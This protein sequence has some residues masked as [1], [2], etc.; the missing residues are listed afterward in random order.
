VD[1]KLIKQILLVL[2]GWRLTLFLISAVAPFIAKYEPS[3]PYA[4]DL[5]AKLDLPQ[6]VYSW[7]NFD[8]VHYLTI[9][10]KGYIGTGL[11]QAF[12]PAFPFLV[13]LFSIGISPLLVALALNFIAVFFVAY[14][15]FLLVR[16][17][18][19]FY[20]TWLSLL[21]LLIFPTSFYLGAV[22]SE[23]FFLAC[24]LGAFV[25]ADKKLWLLATAAAGLAIATRLVGVFL[26][27]A[28]I[29]QAFSGA[30]NIRAVLLLPLSLI[31]LLAYMSF[32]QFEFHDP[33]YFFHVQSEFGSGRQETLIL[34]PQTI[35]RGIKIVFTVP[36]S[37]IWITYAQEL[38]LSLLAFATLLYGYIRRN[39]LRLPL[40]WVL[41]ALGVLLLP[42]LTG[43]LSSMPRYILVAFPLF[44]I[45]AQVLLKYRLVRS[46]LILLSISLLVYN[47]IQFIQG[48]WV[49]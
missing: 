41:Y 32:L 36:F 8:G 27:L 33:F 44:Y 13:R 20:G 49:A 48:H 29:W 12:F 30:R 5:L 45:W 6:W 40:S 22:Y 10:E 4:Y 37:Q 11:I 38:V 1:K 18:I 24:V 21:L 43:T 35:W 28:L 26:L 34:L 16:Q 23:A 3:F 39:K 31:G 47:T 42:T 19:A 7:A 14:F 9:V 46:I 17:R 2:L 25:A 15:L